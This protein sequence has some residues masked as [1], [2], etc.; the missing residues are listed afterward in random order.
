[1]QAT[2]RRPAPALAAAL[3]GLVAIMAVF[4]LRPM[5]AQEDKS[6]LAPSP[7]LS[8][9]KGPAGLAF[10]PLAAAKRS[11]L[12]V[13]GGPRVPPEA[14]AYLAR[15]AAEAGYTSVLASM[16]LDFAILSPAQVVKA[17]EAYP[18]VA[19]W[20]IA[21]HSLGGAA[22]ASFVVSKAAAK[23][24]RAA[25]GLLLLA[26]Y[27]GKGADL[28]TKS[29]PVVTVSASRDALTSPS[30]LA[31]ARSR[32]PAGSRSVEISGGNHAQFG[33]YGPQSGD[34]LAE[35]PGPTQRRAVVEEALALLDRVEAGIEK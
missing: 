34:G 19:R 33:E 12:I 10:V 28:S 32:L 26:S 24:P 2:R 25:S 29:L 5:P 6:L 16:P 30:E 22:A 1:M 18:E 17:A 35:I 21:G 9:V 11:G 14:Y 8:V 4:Y 3:L 13:Y 23:A 20:V 7:A 27:P 15:A 31:A